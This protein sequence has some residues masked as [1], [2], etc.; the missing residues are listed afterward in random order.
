[1]I[2]MKGG[3]MKIE[4]TIN[5]PKSQ[6]VGVEPTTNSGRSRVGLLVNSLP[7][8]RDCKPRQPPCLGFPRVVRANSLPSIRGSDLLGVSIFPASGGFSCASKL[9]FRSKH[10]GIIAI[11]CKP[12]IFAATYEAV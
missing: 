3:R 6:L 12:D 11:P 4:F 7:I 5:T 1:M 9:F 10:A 8:S 2:E